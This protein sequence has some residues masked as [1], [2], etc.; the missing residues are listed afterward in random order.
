MI[1]VST[2]AKTQLILS[3]AAIGICSSASRAQDASAPHTLDT[4]TAT[5]DIVVTAQRRSESIMSVPIAVTALT[6]DDLAKRRITDPGG[7]SSTVPNLQVNDQ[8]G[9]AQPN[10]TLR[11]VGIGNEFSD[12]Q[13]SPIGFYVDDGYVVSRGSQG[14]QLFDLARIEVLRGPQGTLYGRNTTGGAINVITRKPALTGTNGYIESGY[15]NYNDVRAQGALEITPIEGVLGIRFAVDFARH[16]GYFKNIEPN[17]PDLQSGNALSARLSVRLKP[18]DK[19]DINLRLFASR[20]RFW[21]PSNYVIGTGEDGTNPLTGYNRGDLGFFKADTAPLKFDNKAK[22]VQLT[23]RRQLSDTVAIQSITSYDTATLG[24]PQEADGSPVN[25]VLTY[26]NSYA[27]AFNQELRLSYDSGPLKIQGG[28]YYGWDR[29][30]VDN[31]YL[32]FGYLEA[33]GVPADPTLT[34]GGGSI[35]QNYSQT[36]RST[37]AFGQADYQPIDRFTLTLGLRYT[38]D[39][40]R[41]LGTA[42][43]GDYNYQPLVQTVGLPDG[44]PFPNAG[45]NSALTGKAGVSYAIP[46][47]TVYA[48]YSRGYRAGSFNGGAYAANDQ[49]NYIKPETVNAFEVGAKGRIWENTT[50]SAAAFYYGYSN[51]QLSE[52][53]G[54]AIYLQNAGKS[55]IKGLEFELNSRLSRTLTFRANLGL[56]AAKYDKLLLDAGDLLDA[57]GSPV[58]DAAGNPT[59]VVN[60]L[61]GNRPPFAPK[62]TLS[63]GFDWR[64]Y[65]SERWSATLTPTVNYTSKTY[66]TPYDNQGNNGLVKDNGHTL[67][68]LNIA[69]ERASWSF[70]IWGQN[71]TQAKYFVSGNNLESFGY[72][73]LFQGNPRTFGASVKRTF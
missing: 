18:D 69:V 24:Q 56:L 45:K 33:E 35:L 68:N 40:G 15:G 51:Q 4:T 20:S 27:K 29:I 52:I 64:F 59:Q 16:D 14:G 8:T 23:A 31:R 21:Q 25:L 6:G 5:P 42:F 49:T 48:S 63:A 11:G 65:K 50:L 67:L 71:L 54:V 1:K 39:T 57:N 58:L 37:A 41:Y 55:T 10:F 7:L 36:R 22:G 61:K 17:Q 19:T 30:R 2:R 34:T 12:N 3:A 43:A 28:G 70:S 32:L 62:V 38:H 9:G 73:N 46:H 72:I 26:F 13:L 53:R 47:G 44:S 66:F 60:N